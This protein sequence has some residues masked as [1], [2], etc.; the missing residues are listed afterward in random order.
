MRRSGT[1]RDC[2]TEAPR[3]P[4]HFGDVARIAECSG[5]DDMG[6]GVTYAEWM[7]RDEQLLLIERF[8]DDMWNRF[9]KT[10]FAEIL[11][12][13]IQFRGSLGQTKVGFD[14]FGDY[15]DYI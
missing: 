14:E 6:G 2:L 15:V 5:S 9:D 10:V 11:H 12:R 8:Y 7:N 1:G 4:R 13:D 3:V